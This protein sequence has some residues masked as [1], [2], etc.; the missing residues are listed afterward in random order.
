MHAATVTTTTRTDRRRIGRR[1]DH[2]NWIEV[3]DST[4]CDLC[5]RGKEVWLES[6]VDTVLTHVI[7]DADDFPVRSVVAKNGIRLALP[8]AEYERR[9]ADRR[10]TFSQTT[11]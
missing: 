4:Q 11:D 9:R 7:H 8:V 6:G 2:E 3:P 10:G 5:E 1:P